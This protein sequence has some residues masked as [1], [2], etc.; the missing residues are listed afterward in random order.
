MIIASNHLD[1]R[2]LP[3]G[4]VVRVS[5]G[6]YDHVALV[7]DRVVRGERTVFSFSAKA[8]GIVEEP[9]SVFA[10]GRE[11]SIDGYLGGLPSET[12]M[13]RA[14]LKRGQGYSWTEFN[15]E[16]F[17]RYAHGVRVESPQLRK[18]ALLGG[19]VGFFALVARA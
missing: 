13:Q 14:R 10:S 16:H 11:V 3:A 5:H 17:V 8:G 4:T 12:V 1:I 2:S 6:W 18:F 7:G 15:C 19:V 9:Y